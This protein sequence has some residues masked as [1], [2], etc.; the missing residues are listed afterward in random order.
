MIKNYVAYTS[1]IDDESIA[2]EQIKAQ[3]DLDKN[4]MKHSV[5]IISCHYEFVKSGIV[6]AVCNALPFDVAG[7][8]SSY[9]STSD[10]ADSLLMTIMLLTGDDSHFATAVTSSLKQEPG[11]AIAKS[12]AD[13]AS[14]R[15]DKPALILTFAPFM[16]ENSG[17]KY[18]NALTEVSGGIPC[19]G[20]LAVDDTADLFNCFMLFNGE[21]YFDSM[22]MVLVYADISPKFY[23]ANI[24]S[25]NILEKSALVTK[26]SGHVIMELNG[27]P[28]DEYFE[29][30]GLRESSET[31]YA[32]SNLPF[33]LDYNDG[34]KKVSKIFI[35][36]TPE[37]Y[38]LCAGEVPEGSILHIA[39]TS[40]GDV[41]IT[42]A[43]ILDDI[44]DDADKDSCLL[45]YSCIA[46]YISLAGDETGEIS[47][48]RDKVAGK[49]PFMMAYSGGE[50]CP[51]QSLYN[52][53]VNRFHNNSFIACLL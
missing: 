34:T 24:L 16:M 11:K 15:E 50:F 43:Q 19:F 14:K 46:R 9:Q 28:V 47:I 33:M 39:S 30:L 51:T 2:I 31:P 29:D 32:M 41:A 7:A 13:A 22:V 10:A 45:I 20:T 35:T 26:S 53:A 18:I 23:I 49:F 37:R 40:R 44:L 42:T 8:I 48:V 6:K 21:A 27:K 4:L 52:K 1:E 36:L 38:A 12:Y 25:E 5:A 17:D 3:L